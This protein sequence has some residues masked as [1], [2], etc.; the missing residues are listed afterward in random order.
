MGAWMPMDQLTSPARAVPAASAVIAVAA[1][2]TKV[3]VANM[4]KGSLC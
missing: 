2:I 3:F 4:M 1:A